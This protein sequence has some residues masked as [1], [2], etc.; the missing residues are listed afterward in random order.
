[1][2][3]EVIQGWRKYHE[4][5][6]LTLAP[7]GGPGNNRRRSSARTSRPL[8]HALE[9]HGRQRARHVGVRPWLRAAEPPDFGL[10]RP[11]ERD[12]RR[13]HEGRRFGSFASF[14]ISRFFTGY[15]ANNTTSPNS[16]TWRAGGRAEWHV[17]SG[18][19]ISAGYTERDQTWDNQALLNE[20][21]TGTS[22][23]TGFSQSDF[24]SLLST[25]TNIER[26]DKVL[27][28]QASCASSGRSASAS[29][30]PVSTRT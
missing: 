5:E 16:L 2:S 25:Q 18:L 20:L 3:G 14:A 7:F 17:L 15:S 13:R 1:M 4:T 9:H 23:F 29:A 8:A 30:S 10:L 19:D 27:D 12:G 21:Y 28:V 6:D 26:K 22:T 24:Q 11:V